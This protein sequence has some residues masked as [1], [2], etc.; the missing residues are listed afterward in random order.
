MQAWQR[1]LLLRPGLP[2]LLELPG[3]GRHQAW[4]VLRPL[5]GREWNLVLVARRRGLPRRG[6][7]RRGPLRLGPPRR[8]LRGCRRVLGP[9][10]LEPVLLV[11]LARHREPEPPHLGQMAWWSLVRAPLNL[12]AVWLHRELLGRRLQGLEWLHRELEWLRRVWHLPGR[13][14][15]WGPIGPGQ[16]QRR[17]GRA[18]HLPGQELRHLG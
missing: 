18:P 5:P 8:G 2:E 15:W 9:P 16:V 6:L 3:W 11:L 17:Q 13:G 4:L 7:P 12:L 1:L 10:H 14:P